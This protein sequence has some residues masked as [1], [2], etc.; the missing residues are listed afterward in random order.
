[1]IRVKVCD[2]FASRKKARGNFPRIMKVNSII[3]GR[4]AGAGFIPQAHKAGLEIASPPAKDHAA[5]GLKTTG[6]ILQRFSPQAGQHNRRPFHHP[7]IL[8]PIG[9]QRFQ[10]L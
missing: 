2:V 7:G 1:M 5:A 8:R 3:T 9:R 4:L 10:R 6:N